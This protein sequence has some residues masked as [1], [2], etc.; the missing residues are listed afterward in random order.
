MK[1]VSHISPVLAAGV[2]LLAA[3]LL[4]LWIGPGLIQYA[5]LPRQEKLPDLLSRLEDVRAAMDTTLPQLTLHAQKSGVTLTADSVSRNDVCLYM[6]GPNWHEV[7]P[8]RFLAGRPVSAA[9]AEEKARVIVLDEKTAFLFFGDRDPLGQTVSLGDLKLEVIGVAAH[10]RRIGEPG[11]WAAWVPLGLMEDADLMVLSA[12]APASPALWPVFRTAAGDAFGPGEMI[13]LPKEKTAA[14]MMLR[15]ILIAAAIWAMRSFLRRL[16]ALIRRQAALIR[17]ESRRRYAARL[18]PWALWRL[19]PCALG[20]LAAVAAG[21]GLALLAF[22]PARIFP[23]WI[24]ES[25]GDFSAW[26]SRFW[27]LTSAAAQPVSL[28]TPE[29]AELRFCSGLIRWGTVLTLLGF[30]R[31]LAPSVRPGARASKNPS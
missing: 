5:F 15:W 9:D 24:P 6:T 4:A 1:R 2:L 31:L 27:D 12:P 25:L 14:T 19:T 26:V 3:G 16:G 10:D 8:R 28:K 13:C 30:L 23:E 22:A 11:P 20:I 29:L 21:Y 18:I 7:Y 17:E